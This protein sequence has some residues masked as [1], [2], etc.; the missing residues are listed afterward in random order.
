MIFR[1][2]GSWKYQTEVQREAGDVN[3]GTDS[4]GPSGVRGII[5][6]VMQLSLGLPLQRLSL[7]IIIMPG[8]S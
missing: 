6:G 8:M 3:L 4:N 1:I 2:Q 7:N 5:K